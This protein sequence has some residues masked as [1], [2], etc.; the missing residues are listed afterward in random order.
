MRRKSWSTRCASTWTTPAE[1]LEQH[2]KLIGRWNRFVGQY[3]TV[4]KPR[5]VGRPI[6]ASAAQ[7]ASVLKRRKAKDSL[8]T[9]AVATSL[10]LRTVRTIIAQKKRTAA[11]RR[12]EFDRHRAAAYRARKKGR[13]RQPQQLEEQIKTRAQLVKAAKGIGRR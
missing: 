10:S 5:P 11:L 9:I 8:R 3:N 4:I 6:A 13:D 12:H 1:L 2:C 7:Q